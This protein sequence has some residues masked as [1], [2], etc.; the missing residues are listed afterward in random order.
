MGVPYK[1]TTTLM[2][3]VIGG[4]VQMTFAT[5]GAAIPHVKSGR[6]K[7]LAVSSARPSMLVPDLP[8]IAASGVPGYEAENRLGLFAPAK[9][10]PTVIQRLNKELAAVLSTQEIREKYLNIGFD[11]APSSAKEFENYVKSEMSRLAKV[12]KTAGIHGD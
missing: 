2:S 11:A 10:S 9:T 1:T 3:E 8:T 6:L 5:V 12:I 7:A 4:Q